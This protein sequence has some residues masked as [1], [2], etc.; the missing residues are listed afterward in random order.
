[1]CHLKGSG[2]FYLTSL[3]KCASFKIRENFPYLQQNYELPGGENW[4]NIKTYLKKMFL[5]NFFGNILQ[6]V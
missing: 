1:M 5:F 2:S 3:S 6:I 4:I